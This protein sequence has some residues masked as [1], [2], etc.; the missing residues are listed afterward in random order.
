MDPI[1]DASTTLAT[2]SPANGTTLTDKKGWD[3]KLRVGKRA[4]VLIPE[5]PSDPE[6]SDDDAPAVDVEHIEHD[7]GSALAFQPAHGC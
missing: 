5:D 4:E 7:E 3:G 6:Q 2:P 1:T